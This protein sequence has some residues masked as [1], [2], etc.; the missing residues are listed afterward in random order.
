MTE[1]ADREIDK[2]FDEELLPLAARLK[3]SGA[4]LLE[5]RLEDSATSYFARRSKVAMAT[6]DFEV[7]GCVS[8]NT[9]QADLERRWARSDEAPL[10]RLAPGIAKLAGK[11]RESE[12]QSGDVSKFIYVMY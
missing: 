3:E 4:R 10:L 8:P 5:T 2:L 6:A 9:V 1:M 12:Q 7:G 11:L